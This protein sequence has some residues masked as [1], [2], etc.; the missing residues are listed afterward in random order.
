MG[1]HKVS[2][3]LSSYNQPNCLRLV[4]AGLAAQDD[5]DF[6]AIIADDGSDADTPELVAALAA[7]APFPTTFVTQRH[8]V[9]RKARILNQAAR[10]AS[11]D[12]FIFCDGDCVPFHDFIAVHRRHYRPRAYCVGGYVYL[13]LEQSQSLTPDAVRRGAHEAFL[14][15][16]ERRRLGWVHWK[17][18]FYRWVGTRDKPKMLGGNFS[19]GRQVFEEVDGF[20]ESF[21]GFSGEDSDIRNRLNN[22]TARSISLWSAAHVCHLDHTLDPRRCDQGAVRAKRDPKVYYGG[23]TRTRAV[24]GLSQHTSES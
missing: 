24:R 22:V 4:L 16:A 18:C 20:D 8:T 5:L 12:Q 19:V 6:E 3:I 17:N 11:G 13:D 9:F 23:R 21:D 15:P 7:E 10:A 2:L 14:T 1:N